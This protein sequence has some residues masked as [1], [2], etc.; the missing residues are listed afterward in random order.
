MEDVI[1]VQDKFYI[2]ATSSLADDRTLVL[3]H[4]ETFGVFDRHGDMR[5]VGTGVQGLYH[6]GTRHLSRL[7]LRLGEHRPMLL[8]STVKDD[9]A[10]LAVDLTN[11]D[12]PI[13]DDLLVPRGTVHLSR[14]MFLWNGQCYERLRLLNYGLAPVALSFSFHFASDFA[15]IFEVRGMKRARKGHRLDDFIEG[16]SIVLAYEGLDGLVRRTRLEFSMP[17]TEATGDTARFEALLTPRSEMT[18]FLTVS[19]EC[20]DTR[21][22]RISYHHAFSSMCAELNRAKTQDCDLYTSNE[23]FNDWLNRSLDDLH[24]MVTATQQG[25]Y[26]Y[27]GV[28]WFSTPFG[29]DGIITA[30]ETLWI[31]PD[32]TRGVL[33][34]LASTQATEVIPEQ[35]AE[36][37]KILHEARRGEMAALGE[38]PFG[39]YYG[40]VDAG[41]LFVMLAGAYFER[42]GDVAFVERIWPNI[43]LTLKWL[44]TYGDQDGDGFVEYS[45]HS[46]NG[47]VHQAWKDSSD[48]VFHADGVLADAPIAICEVQAYVYAA[49]RAAAQIASAI[50]RSSRAEALNDRASRLQEHFEAIFWCDDLGTYILALDGEKRPCR[51]RASNAG[52]CLLAGIATEEHARIVAQTLLGDDM[53]SGWGIRTLGSAEQRYNPMSY[54][55]GSVWPH[56]NALIALGLARYGL[57]D[58]VLKIL[59]GM[60]DASLFV[61]QHRLPELFCG[62]RRR[63]GQAPTR[64]PVA[65]APQAWASGTVFLLLQAT[66]G[67]TIDGRESRLCFS[68]PLLPEFLQRVRIKNLRVGSTTVDVSL[69]RKDREVAVHLMR[70]NGQ[71]KIDKSDYV[72]S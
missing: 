29:R 22:P 25:P 57:K 52:H 70:V 51:V 59:T 4:G 16:G 37:G 38:I 11:T 65:C 17:P 55:N 49:Y 63:P 66:L 64:Y 26:P 67:L 31:N 47:L 53:F 6:D 5:H 46:V 41:P 13:G 24:M 54:H 33:A 43:E 15:D 7:E 62:F 14:T 44:E 72:G 8:S 42:T 39:R 48:P 18:L 68:K 3:K 45:R 71:V 1:Q 12:A 27:A 35:D 61:D 58:E 34:F 50:G 40:S 28:P 56:D 36:P 21:A 9:N 30:F 60:F 23:G 20:A 32:L 69:E 2:L 19:C 10:L